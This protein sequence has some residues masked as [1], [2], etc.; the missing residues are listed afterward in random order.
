MKWQ[1]V[2]LMRVGGKSYVIAATQQVP[3]ANRGLLIK[4]K[5]KANKS[6]PCHVCHTNI[7]PSWCKLSHYSS[8]L[9][10]GSNGFI[11]VENDLLAIILANSYSKIRQKVRY[12]Y[13]LSEVPILQVFTLKQKQICYQFINLSPTC[14]IFGHAINHMTIIKH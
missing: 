2:S 3:H 6:I 1:N 8:S 9:R 11:P 4:S 14:S 10:P 7:L 5:G 12:I 13:P